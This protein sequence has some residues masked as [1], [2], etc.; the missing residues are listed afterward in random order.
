MFPGVRVCDM[1]ST[2]PLG[3]EK[4]TSY[5]KRDLSAC[6]RNGEEV[7]FGSDGCSKQ[8]C[9][10]HLCNTFLSSYLSSSP[11]PI[12]PTSS[13]GRSVLNC[14]L[15]ELASENHLSS[16]TFKAAARPRVTNAFT[17]MV[18]FYG[19]KSILRVL[20]SSPFWAFRSHWELSFNL[21]LKLSEVDTV[22]S[23]LCPA[24]GAS[25]ETSR[26]NARCLDGASVQAAQECLRT[27]EGGGKTKHKLRYE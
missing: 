2:F 5:C 25:R 18:F 11:L 3:V 1:L 16:Q 17:L 14:S 24:A 12:L 26:C 21:S 13:C 22:N 6:D 15:M 20:L 23:M 4:N 10:W 19:E 9:C 27:R 7:E 8:R